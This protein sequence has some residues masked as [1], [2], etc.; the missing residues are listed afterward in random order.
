MRAVGWARRGY[1]TAVGLYIRHPSSFAH[2]TGVHPENAQR[3][4]AIEAALEPREWLGLELVEA[5]RA[6]RDQILRVHSP[7]HVDAIEELCRRGGGMIDMDTVAVEASFDAALH[8][9]GGAVHAVDRMLADG[10]R[11]AFCGLR[12][13]ATTRRPRA[14]WASACSTTLPWP[15]RTRSRSG[16]PNGF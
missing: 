16:A 4:R 9:A 5:P 8:A 6:S 14:R 2:E 11:L 12:P 15:R 7:A 1:G 10:E 13:R 3:L